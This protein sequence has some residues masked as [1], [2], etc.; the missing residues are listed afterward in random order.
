MKRMLSS[1]VLLLSLG[2]GLYAG[3]GAENYDLTVLSTNDTHGHPLD[4][5]WAA[6]FPDGVTYANPDIGGLP[7]RMTYVEQVRKE[8]PNV[9]VLDAGDVTT[10]LVVSNYF[11]TKPDIAGM[12]AIGYHAMALGNHEFD[13]KLSILQERKAEA[14][15]PFISANVVDKVS[16]KPYTQPYVIIKLKDVRVGVIGVTTPET[17]TATLPANVEALSFTDPVAAV[18]K[19]VAEIKD[20]ADF[21]VVLSHLGLNEDR[22]LAKGINGVG[23]ILGGHSHNYMAK[24]EVVNNI[25]IFQAYQ[26]GAYVGRV[27]IQVRDKKVSSVM[28]KPVP[29]NFSVE[30]KEG[31]AAKGVVREIKGKKYDYL[32]GYLE[33]NAEL[34]ATLKPYADEVKK[35]LETVVAKASG[36]FPDT[37]NG[38]ARYPRR[39]DSAL[40]NMLVD[41]MRAATEQQ[42]GKKVDIFFQN[43]GGIRAAIPAGD[44]SKNTIYAVLP[45]DNTIQTAVLTGAQVLEILEKTAL[46]VAV[47]NYTTGFDSPNGAFLQV[48]GM[49]YTIDIAAKQISDVTV[50]GK[51]LDL[52]AS[53]LI[54]TQNFMMTGGDGYTTLKDI[55]NPFETSMFQRDA[56]LA[57]IESN[58]VLDPAVYEDNRINVINTGK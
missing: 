41:A 19:Y 4:Y 38:L 34:A 50:G 45:F 18:K 47:G 14:K 32:Y 35:N 20:K 7:A 8:V 2:F 39:D 48:S 9:L 15:F 44:V 36:P 27:D 24:E 57:W 37:V 3:G 22:E 29:I 43:G 17:V 51:P 42:I 52:T 33:P 23:L 16:G 31:T 26:W 28:A 5:A 56:V 46:P 49:R 6:K 25:P 54:G 13:N 10:G 12:N 1:L 53:Y 55:K 21:I 30:L 11:L 40:S 58:K